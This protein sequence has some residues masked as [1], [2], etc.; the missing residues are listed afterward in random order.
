MQFS[1]LSRLDAWQLMLILLVLMIISILIGLAAGK[2]FY[3]KSEIDAT[4]LGSLFTLLGLLLAFTFS[5]SVSY[6]GMRRDIIIEEANDIGTAI[7]RADLYRETDRDLLRTDFK[8]YVDA[9]IEFFTAGTD[10]EKVMAAQQLSGNIQQQLWNRAAQ[11]SKDS[12]YTVASMQM[13]PALNSMIDIT[14]TR[15]YSNLVHLPDTIIYLLLLLSCT[16]AFY[17]GYMFAGKG[18][19]DW[20]MVIVFSLLTSMVVFVIFDLDRP[21]RG[22]I[23]LDSMN[24]AIIELKQQFQEK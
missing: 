8:K 16:C 5:M 7:L 22:F 24:N 21:R 15:K 9:R 4:V 18:K 11:L 13:I 2:K 3:R 19:F 12:G 23:T 20:V 6:H 10:I 14:T 1:F 17:I